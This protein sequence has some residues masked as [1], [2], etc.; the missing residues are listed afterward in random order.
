MDELSLLEALRMGNPEALK[1]LYI[2][3]RKPVID[4]CT[5]HLNLP[6]DEAQEYYHEVILA[7]RR[8]LDNGRLQKLTSTWFAYLTVTAK[9]LYITNWRKNSNF[10][11]VS[12]DALQKDVA[13]IDEKEEK[14]EKEALYLRLVEYAL[15]RLN[16]RD[17]NLLLAYYYEK[18]SL[19]EIAKRFN[20]PNERAA[21]MAKKRA[22]QRLRDLLRP[23]D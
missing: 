15:P 11:A 14:E 3:Y 17:R 6:F 5:N 2:T 18:C 9:Y 10:T 20:F 13:T 7:V 23:F 22:L 12:L 1:T 4:W 16:E 19:R 8:N 21:I